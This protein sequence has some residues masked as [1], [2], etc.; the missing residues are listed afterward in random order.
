M[1]RIEPPA[2]ST[3][4]VASR[5]SRLAAAALAALLSTVLPASP[6]LPASAGAPKVGEKAPDFQLPDTAGKRISLSGLLSADPKGTWVLLVF[7]RGY[8]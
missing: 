8:W 1:S 4:A 7:Y 6:S 5:G 2:R 3:R